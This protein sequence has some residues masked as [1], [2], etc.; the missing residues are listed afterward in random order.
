MGLVHEM[1]TCSWILA[2]SRPDACF[3]RDD[4]AVRSLWNKMPGVVMAMSYLGLV[5]SE[6]NPTDALIRYIF[7]NAGTG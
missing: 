3:F 6:G 2:I 4:E 7:N 5:G 1:T